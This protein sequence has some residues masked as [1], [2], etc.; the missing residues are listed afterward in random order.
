M[1]LDTGCAVLPGMV[2]SLNNNI[3]FL[4]LVLAALGLLLHRLSLVVG[5]R[6]CSLAAG[7]GLLI[8]V[9]SLAAKCGPRTWVQQL[10]HTG[11]AAQRLVGSS[12]TRDRTC[13]PCIGRQIFTT[14]LPGK[15]SFL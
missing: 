6:R 14:E 15:S 9:A 8:V 2:S 1:L 11:L 12:Q 10:W 3:S 7:R 5:N 13:V 4:S